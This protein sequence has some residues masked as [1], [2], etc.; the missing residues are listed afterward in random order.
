MPTSGRFDGRSPHRLPAPPRSGGC[1]VGP[2]QARYWQIG[3]APRDLYQ[4]LGLPAYWIVDPSRPSLLALRQVEGG[5]DV[6]ADTSGTFRTEWPFLVY[7]IVA[8]LVKVAS[9]QLPGTAR[10]WPLRASNAPIPDAVESR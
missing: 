3:A 4:R 10:R 9:R 6:E 5:F 2:S 1:E 7:L 8:E